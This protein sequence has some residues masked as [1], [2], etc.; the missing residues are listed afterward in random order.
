MEPS[1]PERRFGALALVVLAISLA[2]NWVMSIWALWVAYGMKYQIIYGYH[3]KQEIVTAVWKMALIITTL[4]CVVW[5]LADRKKR[6]G[7]GGGWVGMSH[8]RRAL[9]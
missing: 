2:I 4:T 8:G 7:G 3:P 9:S 6:S 5:L 1:T